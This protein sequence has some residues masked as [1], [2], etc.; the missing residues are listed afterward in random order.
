MLPDG[1]DAS[2]VPDGILPG[3][4]R[5]PAEQIKMRTIFFLALAALATAEPGQ[6]DVDDVNAPLDGDVHNRVKRDIGYDPDGYGPN[7][8]VDMEINAG[9]NAH[10]AIDVDVNI[11]KNWLARF[12]LF[13]LA[14][15]EGCL[16]LFI[17]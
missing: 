8:N 11:G 3:T 15:L 14:L 13:F 1:A 5:S 4:S 17:Y 6:S 7:I 9:P 12:C 10:V 2:E 16:P